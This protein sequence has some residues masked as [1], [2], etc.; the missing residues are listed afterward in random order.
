MAVIRQCQIFQHIEKHHCRQAVQFIKG[1]RKD[2]SS[3]ARSVSCSHGRQAEWYLQN[4]CDWTT[5]KIQFS[6]WALTEQLSKHAFVL[7]SPNSLTH[8]SWET[9]NSQLSVRSPHCCIFAQYLVRTGKRR[10]LCHWKFSGQIKLCTRYYRS[11]NLSTGKEKFI[12]MSSFSFADPSGAWCGCCPR[13]A[14]FVA[15]GNK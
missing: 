2:R 4:W 11:E 8:C 13:W 10:R 1:L 15:K 12:S 3:Q 5:Q 14:F 7:V 6:W 9:P